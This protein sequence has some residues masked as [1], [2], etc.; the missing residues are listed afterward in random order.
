MKNYIEEVDENFS[1]FYNALP[2]GINSAIAGLAEYNEKFKIS[3]RRLVSLQ[4]WRGELIEKIASEGAESFFKE[5]QN[6]AIM[7][8][9]LARQGAWRVALMSL[10]SCIENSL[11]GLYYFEHPV[12]LSQWQVGKFRIG[13]TEV[14]NYLGKHPNFE[15]IGEQ[16]SGIEAIKSEYSTLSKAVHGSSNSF[17]VTKNGS[18]EGLNVISIADLGAW[19]TRERN[20]LIALNTIFLTMFKYNLQGASNSN[21]RKAVSLVIPEKNHKLIKEKLN[22]NLRTLPKPNPV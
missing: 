14:V 11:Y 10:R 17:R 12:E 4:A 9:S 21:L 5:A 7:S 19:S 8:H 3:Y 15:E 13:F 22:I 6:D 16:D 2:D 1:R 20:A 18:I